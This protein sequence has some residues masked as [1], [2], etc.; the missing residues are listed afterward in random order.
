[1]SGNTM[2]KSFRLGYERLSIPISRNDVVTQC[3]CSVHVVL[4]T[5]PGL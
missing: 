3:S 1:M 5:A 4:A 2:G